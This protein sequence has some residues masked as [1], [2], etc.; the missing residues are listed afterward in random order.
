[1]RRCDCES[2]TCHPQ[3][4][5]SSEGTIKTIYSTV[6]VECAYQMPEEYLACKVCRS[7]DH[8]TSE[9]YVVTDELNTR[10]VNDGKAE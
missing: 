3:A 5:C 6:C 1:M 7:C 8:F 10:G 9:H 2:A 4:D